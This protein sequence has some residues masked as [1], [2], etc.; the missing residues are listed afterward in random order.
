MSEEISSPDLCLL[1][2]KHRNSTTMSVGKFAVG[3]EDVVGDTLV[4]AEHL[5]A[6][7]KAKFITEVGERS[8]Y[9][10]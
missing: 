10:V 6:A 5:N 3:I 7:N 2:Q 1:S 8:D 9:K 4:P